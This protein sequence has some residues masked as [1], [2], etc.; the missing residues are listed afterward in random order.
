MITSIGQLNDGYSFGVQRKSRQ[1][2]PLSQ[3]TSMT[4][5]NM[6]SYTYL[7]TL[8]SNNAISNI[9]LIW[10]KLKH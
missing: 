1:D 6:L 9:K 2:G 8:K 10:D 3:S 5:L 7:F 4:N